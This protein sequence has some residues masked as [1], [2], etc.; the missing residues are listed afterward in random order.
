MPIYHTTYGII[1]DETIKND[2]QEVYRNTD[3]INNKIERITLLNDLLVAS[4][5]FSVLCNNVGELPINKYFYMMQLQDE[6]NSLRTQYDLD[7]HVYVIFK[8]ND[9][10]VSGNLSGNDYN[11]IPEHDI[12]SPDFY[13]S[14]KQEFFPANAGCIFCLKTNSNPPPFLSRHSSAL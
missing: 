1:K 8:N 12:Y 5:S 10:L 14:I 4:P 11:T 9:V 7:I 6:I 13:Q 2:A 3:Q